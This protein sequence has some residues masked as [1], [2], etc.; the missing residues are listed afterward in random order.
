[1]DE[2]GVGGMASVHLARMDGPGGFQKWVAIKRIH[3][4]LVEDDQFV[5]M[6][7]DEARIAAGINHANVA[8]V[9]DL[10][11]DDNTYWIAMEYLHGEPLREVMRRAEERGLQLSP[12]LAARMCADAAEGLHAAHELRGKN[13]Q[14]LGLVHRDVTPHN[15]FI[16][17]DGYTKVVDFGIAKVADRLSST[18]AG[19]LKGKLAY[20]SPEQVSGVKDIDRTTDIFALGVVLWELTTN[21]RLFRMDTDLDTLEKVQKCEVPP[22]STLIPN[23]P[24]ELEAIVLKALAKDRR[25]RFATAREFSRALQN[26]LMRRGAYVG[27]EEVAQFVRQVFAD[28]I[29]K[30]EQHL[31]WAAEVTSTINVDQLKATGNPSV[32]GG[33]GGGREDDDDLRRSR[34]NAPRSSGSPAS[35]IGPIGRAAQVESQMAA[36]SLMDD[37]E[38]VPTTVANRDQLEPR[39]VGPE[40]MGPRPAAGMPALGAAGPGGHPHGMGMGR[41][42]QAEPGPTGAPP[43]AP[44][45]MQLPS[46]A[47]PGPSPYGARPP[48]NPYSQ[49]PPFSAS[50]LDERDDDLGATLALPS[51]MGLGPSP[52]DRPRP[53]F[54]PGPAASQLPQGMGGQG[55]GGPSFGAP[56]YNGQGYGGPP[57]GPQ[58]YPGVRHGGAPSFGPAPTGPQPPATQAFPMHFPPG[59]QP[60]SQIETALSLPRP[61]PAAL[62]MAQQDAAKR[63]QRRN[64]GVIIAV[65]ALTALCLIG[66]VA[67]VYFKM[68]RTQ[69][70]PPSVA[71]AADTTMGAASPPSAPT[72]A[73]V[74]APPPEAPA[75]D[76]PPAQPSASPTAAAAAA[77]AALSAPSSITATAAVA[78]ASS[79]K[80]VT[81]S[82]PAAAASSEPKEV[83]GYLTIQ[84]DPQCDEVLDNGRSLGPSPVMRVAASPGQHRVTGRKGTTR[85]VISVIVVSGSVSAHRIAMK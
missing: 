11:K 22:P 18:R 33:S 76:A 5:D 84:C 62:W 26:F 24:L 48:G 70:P 50:S 81:A 64:T 55:M 20:M 21:Q 9:F 19:T 36:S 83:P 63:G 85:K 78:P 17:Y 2:I 56:P 49:P 42:L 32:A 80:P 29:E 27:P 7:L 13:G 35:G 52:T 1:M 8:Q 43:R 28:R 16:T 68:Q 34:G 59:H 75:D 41:P 31:A 38:D 65:V 4:H 44:A 25:Q 3:P 73:V 61:D 46:M 40:R 37:D 47:G 45:T 69:A 79:P 82:A 51:T 23:Y 39:S 54:G 77:P 14:L 72:E 71:P 60:Q 12:E 15:L 58:G 6:F 74:A 53:A 66:I 30:R 67:L 10:G 57:A